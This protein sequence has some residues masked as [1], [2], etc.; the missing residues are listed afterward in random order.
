MR[1]DVVLHGSTA[2]TGLG[3]LLFINAHDPGDEAGSEIST[4]NFIEVRPMG[5]SAKTPIASKRDG[6]GRSH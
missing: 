6:R 1:L 5:G 4:N 2:A 3:E